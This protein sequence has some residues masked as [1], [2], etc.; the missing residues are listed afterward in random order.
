MI[1]DNE[2]LYRAVKKTDP[3]SFINDRP[4]AALFIDKNG[5]SVDRDG[6]RDEKEIID[7]FIKRFNRNGRTDN[8]IATVK[9]LAK[10][11]RDVDCY[12]IPRKTNNNKNHAEIWDSESVVEIGLLKAIKLAELCKVV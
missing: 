10:E 6:G 1:Q 3:N 5:V 4:C 8:Y 9:I 2:L 12:P 11:C 7:S